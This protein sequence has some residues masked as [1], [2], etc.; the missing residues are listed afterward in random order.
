MNGNGSKT[1]R[2]SKIDNRPWW[3]SG[4]KCLAA[5]LWTFTLAVAWRV[6]FSYN[7]W[8]MS[9]ALLLGFGL[10]LSIMVSGVI[11]TSGSRE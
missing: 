11:A 5:S 3:H 6:T 1:S 4:S 10:V 7:G 9:S 2:K 8:T